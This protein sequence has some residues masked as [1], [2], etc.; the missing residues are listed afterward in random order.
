MVQCYIHYGCLRLHHFII[1]F[2]CTSVLY[3]DVISHVFTAKNDKL[4]A[5]FPETTK[6]N[7]K[8]IRSF[9]DALCNLHNYTIAIVIIRL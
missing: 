7:E 2:F 4:D 1:P 5:S 8:S 9:A 6:A 3:F